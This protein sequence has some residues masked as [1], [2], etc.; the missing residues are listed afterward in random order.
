MNNNDGIMGWTKEN[1]I[2]YCINVAKLN[3]NVYCKEPIRVLEVYQN[4]LFP[5]KQHAFYAR[6]WN[7]TVIDSLNNMA[8][9]RFNDSEVFMESVKGIFDNQEEPENLEQF[10]TR[11]NN[12]KTS[13]EE[14]KGTNIDFVAWCMIGIQNYVVKQL[15][16]LYKKEISGPECLI[17]YVYPYASVLKLPSSKEEISW[18]FPSLKTV[19]VGLNFK[20]NKDTPTKCCFCLKQNT[21]SAFASQY[22]QYT[23]FVFTTCND[24][25]DFGHYYN[26]CY[27]NIEE[28]VVCVP[29]TRENQLD[30]S[31]LEKK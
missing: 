6:L 25:S 10:I 5:N 9:N 28:D 27:L 8:C 20:P 12:I 18:L 17:R 23:Y 22:T 4:I 3:I 31:C 30:L 29:I 13:F 14:L 16:K 24:C 2:L 11:I 15:N 21:K 26:K 1:A 7:E 19:F